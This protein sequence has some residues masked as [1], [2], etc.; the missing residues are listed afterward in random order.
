M[1]DV[2]KNSV[3]DFSLGGRELK[4]RAWDG[5]LRYSEWYY[6]DEFFSMCVEDDI[7]QFTGLTDIN[8]EDI[9]EGDIVKYNDDSNTDQVG[10]VKNY[11]YLSIYIEAVGGDDEGNQ[12]IELHPDY[13][14]EIIGNVFQNPDLLGEENLD[15]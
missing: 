7:T 2:T 10:V 15:T 11:G 1:T 5:T 6:L 14:I 13:K 12:D 8:T 4:F 3:Q 9:Y